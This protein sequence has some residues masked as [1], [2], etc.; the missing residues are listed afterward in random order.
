MET[1]I[2]MFDVWKWHVSEKIREICGFEAD[3]LTDYPYRE[4]YDAGEH[5]SFVAY[6]VLRANGYFHR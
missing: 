5:T 2:S 3:D 6:E 4:S 1:A